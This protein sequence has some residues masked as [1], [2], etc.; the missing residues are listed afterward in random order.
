MSNSIS[1]VV[2]GANV[3]HPL[4]SMPAHSFSTR[5]GTEPLIPKFNINCKCPTRS[6][7]LHTAPTCDIFLCKF[8]ELCSANMMHILEWIFLLVQEVKGRDGSMANRSGVEN[9]EYAK[10]RPEY[11]IL[12]RK[13]EETLAWNLALR[14]A[15]DCDDSASSQPSKADFKKFGINVKF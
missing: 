13:R 6:A 3:L 2:H 5:L 1:N 7:M 11:G 14:M 12:G 9:E 8:H 15:D 10:F 4:H